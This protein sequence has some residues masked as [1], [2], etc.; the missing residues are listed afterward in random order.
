MTAAAITYTSTEKKR[1]R[2]SFAKRAAVLNVPFLLATQLD[3]FTAF[4]QAA[5]PAERRKNEGLQAAFTSIF[6]IESHSKNAR[7]DFVSYSLGQPPFDVK[8]CQ[9]RGLTYAAPLRVK[10]RLTIMDREASKPTVKEVKEQEVYMGELPLMT[11][12]GSFVINGTE[13]VIVSQLHRSPGVFFEHDRGKTHSSGKLL[14]S[15]RIIPYRGS[16]LDF[17]FDPK[18]CVF[19]RID[20][21][22]KLPV[23]II[24]RALGYTEEQVLDMFFEKNVFHLSKKE[25]EFEIIPQRLRGETA[26]FEIRVGKKVIVEEGRR[27]TAR[28]VRDLEEAQVKRLPVPVEYLQ[29]K[30]LAHDIVN[31]E[32]GEILAKANEILTV[33]TVGKLIEGGITEIRTLSANDL[34][35]GPY[36]SDTLRIDPTKTRLEALVEIYR[37][38]RPGEPPTKDAAEN[39]F[40]N[41]F[42]NGERYDLS[43]VGRMK[44]SRRVGREEITGSGVLSKEDIIE[45]MKTLIDIRNGNG[46]VDD[47]DHLGNR[48]VRSVGEMAE[49]A[50]RIGLV[51]VER[52][53][54]ERLTIAESE[55]IMPQEMINAKPVAAAVKEFFGSSQL[56]QFMDQN[57]PLS[58]VTHK[59]RVSP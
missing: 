56:S 11:D 51:R 47:I 43:P 1:I 42:F 23:T 39:L 37:M 38:M 36:I 52:A 13:R 14:F 3:S 40:Q 24:L 9:Q 27:I 12:N 22:R 55:P 19:A 31:T 35:R 32:T 25:I 18:D 48:R 57:N 17:E 5:V 41:L 44:F 4:L 10:V 30:V 15:A 6:P 16:W 45:V 50:F 21:R 59:R 28:H 53:V 46:H 54:K 58:E 49:N 8:E 34:D 33:P 20:R 2:K 26:S 29:G 7:L